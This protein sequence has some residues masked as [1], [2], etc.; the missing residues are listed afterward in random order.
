MVDANVQDVT[1]EIT[2]EEVKTDEVKETTTSTE[3]DAKTEAQKIADAMVAK[4]LK[5]M[6]SKEEL[7]AYKEWQESQKTEAEKTNEKVTAAE[8]E[9][10]EALAEAKSL[11]ATVSCLKQGVITDSVDD[12]VALAQRLV[13]EDVT[14]DDA[15]KQVVKKYPSFAFKT[16]DTK[17]NVTTGTKTT[18]TTTTNDMTLR[19]A[20]GLK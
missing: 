16:A 17:P 1:E 4:K 15:I 18:Q 20:M 3:I 12:V 19:K 5:G 11:K 6:P 8:K 10:L 9:K 7:K 2:T 13:T 14:I